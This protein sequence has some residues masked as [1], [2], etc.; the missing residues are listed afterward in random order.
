MSPRT[1]RRASRAGLRRQRGQA[2]V[3]AALGSLMLA[4]LL[5]AITLIGK[6]GDLRHATHAAARTLAFECTVRHEACLSG[7][8]DPAFVDE[9]RARHFAQPA[10]APFTADRVDPDLPPGQRLPL[11]SDRRGTPLLARAGDVGATIVTDRFDAGSAVAT[12]R[13]GPAL[14]RAADALSNL[15][16]PG[17]FGFGLTEGLVRTRVQASLDGAAA[18]AD[19]GW[20][21]G[22]ERLPL[23]IGGRAAVLVDAWNASGSRA[24]P[25]SVESRVQ[26][27]A[28][29]PGAVEAGLD[30]AYAP[31]RAFLALMG[32]VGLEPGA[33]A[34]DFHHVDVTLLP[35]DREP[36]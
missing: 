30:L 11:W 21:I 14:S 4:A 36:R 6:Y 18:P 27:G 20:Q 1:D 23:R 32:A 9:L 16:G 12:S 28:Q 10:P 19:R 15:A 35:A 3:E 22:I 13:A 17:R 33:D 29:L 8:L 26:A 24:G 34:F 5:V 25:R 2:L 7:A 31:T